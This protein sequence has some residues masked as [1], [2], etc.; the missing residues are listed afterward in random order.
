M[1]VRRTGGYCH[2]LTIAVVKIEAD[3]VAGAEGGDVRVFG[4]FIHLQAVGHRHKSGDHYWTRLKYALPGCGELFPRQTS[5]L[6]EAL[7]S[8]S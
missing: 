7:Q 8:P 5:I 2:I 4:D 3:A 6:L 1:P